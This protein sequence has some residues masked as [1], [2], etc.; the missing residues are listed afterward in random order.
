VW[1]KWTAPCNGNATFTTSQTGF[2]TVMGVYSG[3][4]LDALEALAEDDDGISDYGP[5]SCTFPCVR[6]TTY[7]IAVGGADSAHGDIVLDWSVEE[8][9]LPEIDLTD[10]NADELVRELVQDNPSLAANVTDAATYDD[11]RT[12]VN[13]NGINPTTALESTDSFISFAFDLPGI[14]DGEQLA[15]KRIE[16]TDAAIEGGGVKLTV[17]IEDIPVGAAAQEQYLEKVFG[18]VGSTALD[19]AFAAENVT[20]RNDMTNNGDGTVSYSAE[21]KVGGGEAKPTAFFFKAK[22]NR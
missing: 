2:D 20:Y 4:S 8:E 9:I 14:V 13:D 17:A 22:V 1:W 12:W 18:V 5:S 10:E 15:S 6:G 21:P 3:S 16:V 11:F 19:G 7:W